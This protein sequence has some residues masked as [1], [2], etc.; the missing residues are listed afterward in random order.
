MT[1]LGWSVISLGAALLAIA[2]LGVLRL[3]GALARQ[4]A[5]T[6]AATFA[7]GTMVVGV[8]ILQPS[9]TWLWRLG[10]LA[11]VVLVTVP[12]AS[13][14]LARAAARDEDEKS[15]RGGQEHA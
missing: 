7:L 4:H 12:I 1:V 6:K 13:H 5:A 2:A 10:L 15:R 11:V 8:G 9:A 14:A 3:P